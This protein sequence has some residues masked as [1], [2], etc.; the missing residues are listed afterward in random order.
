MIHDRVYYF[1]RQMI[2]CLFM[3]VVILYMIK[4]GEQIACLHNDV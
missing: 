4:A 2:L 1:D 3:A